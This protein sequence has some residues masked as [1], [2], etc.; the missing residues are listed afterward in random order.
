ME[1]LGLLKN[2]VYL[3]KAVWRIVPSLH[4][5][6]ETTKRYARLAKGNVRN[7]QER[8][9]RTVYGSRYTRCR[10]NTKKA[11]RTYLSFIPT[12]RGSSNAQSCKNEQRQ[13]PT[14]I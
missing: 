12:L 11:W 10:M 3:C 13:S 8:T 2:Y 7:F 6:V 9:A 14:P 1:N 5:I 4:D